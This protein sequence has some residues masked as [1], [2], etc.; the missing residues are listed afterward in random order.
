[1]LVNLQERLSI[2]VAEKQ[3]RHGAGLFLIS[4]VRSAYKSCK[5][6]TPVAAAAVAA[7]AAAGAAAA[8]AA[9]AAA[10]AAGGGGAAAA[11][12][13]FFFFWWQCSLFQTLGRGGGGQGVDTHDGEGV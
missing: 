5:R 4:C 2:H 7:V 8:A 3:V 11:A 1:M 9:G 10:A 13:F 12:C 6:M